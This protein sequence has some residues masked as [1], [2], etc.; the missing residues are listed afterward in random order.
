MVAVAASG[1]RSSGGGSVS[2]SG[3]G[4]DSRRLVDDGALGMQG[5]QVRER[6]VGGD[7]VGWGGVRRGGG[8]A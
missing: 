7:G 5:G 2:S 6:K 8:A 4:G 1:G 3:G